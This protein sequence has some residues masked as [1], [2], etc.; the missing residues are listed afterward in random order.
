[1]NY[2][3]RKLKSAIIRSRDAIKQKYRELH[4]QRLSHNE[5]FNFKYKPII[6]PINKLNENI[7]PTNKFNK[8]T[9]PI[10]DSVEQP[11][12]AKTTKQSKYQPRRLI[13]KSPESSEKKF[14][15][16]VAERTPIEII[17]KSTNSILKDNKFG[18]E[19]VILTDILSNEFKKQLSK[20]QNNKVSRTSK[21]KGKGLQTDYMIVNEN[22]QVP[23]FT[24]WDD[25]N[26]LVE[27]LRLLV[28][29]KSAGHS[30][31]NNE[32]LSI[33]EELRE[34]NIIY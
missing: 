22:N 24:Y 31:H 26:E 30:A 14:T 10:I 9:S 27:R 8:Y 33:I 28:S 23:E 7:V 15:D 18:N 16:S 25:P 32:I 12:N 13:F 20:N 2:S 19:D 4:Q 3:E 34:A 1:M 11:I 5:E 29:S 17:D 21:R 6:D